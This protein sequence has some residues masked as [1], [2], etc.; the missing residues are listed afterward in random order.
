MENDR[1]KKLVARRDQIKA[2]IARLAAQKQAQE[3]R[4]ET[5]R[6]IVAGAILLDAVQRD[7]VTE[8]PSGL[9]RWWDSQV[10]GLTRPQDQLLFGTTT[11]GRS[12]AE[13]SEATSPTGE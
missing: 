9:A 6:K 8:C 10:A 13:R 3:R 2:Q 5:R 11:N 4:D 1:L 12:N 7:R